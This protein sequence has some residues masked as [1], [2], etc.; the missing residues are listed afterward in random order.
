M[1][2]QFISKFSALGTKS[3]A[4]LKWKPRLSLTALLEEK[5]SGEL[6]VEI[7][8]LGVSIVKSELG[9]RFVRI[10]VILSAGRFNLN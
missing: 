4:L 2:E 8:V 3:P 5:V 1:R 6:P 7:V 10:G 9:E